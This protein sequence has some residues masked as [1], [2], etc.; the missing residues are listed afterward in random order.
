MVLKDSLQHTEKSEDFNEFVMLCSKGDTQIRA[1]DAE[2]K[3][4][5]WTVGSKIP[6]NQTNTIFAPEN[7]PAVTVAG[8]TG[9]ALLDLSAVKGKKITQEEY[10]R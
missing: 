4:G 10:K 5:K 6:E 1:Y 7:A 2:R 3:S 8:Y 9:P